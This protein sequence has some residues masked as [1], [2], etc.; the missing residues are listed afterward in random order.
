MLATPLVSTS[1]SS[2]GKAMYTMPE[3]PLPSVLKTLAGSLLLTHSLVVVISV[4][5]P[6]DSSVA[7]AIPEDFSPSGLST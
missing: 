1:K 3:L 6:M 5:V 7:M 4:Q 2:K